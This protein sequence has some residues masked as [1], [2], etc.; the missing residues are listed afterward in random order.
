MNT[1]FATEPWSSLVI[2]DDA[3]VRQSLRLCLEVEGA[4][5]LGVATAE[6]ALEAL[7]RTTFDV[8]FLDLWLGAESGLDALPDILRKQPGIGVVVVTAYASFETAVQAMKLGASDYLPKPFTPEQVR[9]AARR[10]VEAKRLQVEHA[11]LR[12]RVDAG[13]AAH[14]FESRSARYRSFIETATRAASADSVLLLRGE[15]GTGKNVL[16]RWI[17]RTSRRKAG[18]FV[19]VHCP[20]LTGDLMTSALFGHRKGAFT[21]AVADMAGK[22]EEAEGGTLFLDEVGDLSADAQARLLRCLNDRTYERLGEARERHADVRLV[23][24]TNRPIEEESRSGRFR[25]DLLFRLNVITLTLP[26]LRDRRED[27][28]PIAL[29]FLRFFERTHGRTGLAFRADTEFLVTEYPWPGNLRELR[30]AIERAVT[31]A[32]SGVL[33]PEDLGLPEADVHEILTRQSAPPNR[34]T[35]PVEVGADVSLEELEREHIARLVARAPTFDAAAR[36]LGIDITTLHRK[37]KR[38]RLA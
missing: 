35:V 20:A 14:G 6:A 30:N 2:D 12:E 21:G 8:V 24:A 23:A 32:P 25:E 37:R 31:L 18:P 4:R 38:Y 3:T 13:M 7:E 28:L 26:A 10:V 36:T 5:V 1:G 9:Q 27:V 33:L 16:A 22:V 17:H 19:T 29:H 11:R 34:R 15:S